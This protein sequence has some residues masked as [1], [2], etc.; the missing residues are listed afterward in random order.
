MPTAPLAVRELDDLLSQARESLEKANANLDPELVSVEQAHHLL[1][2]YA[3]VQRLAAYGETVLARRVDDAKAVAAATGTTVGKAKE[4]LNTGKAMQGASGLDQAMRS[5]ELSADQA[6]PIAKALQDNPSAEDSLLDAAR[7][8]SV[9]DLKERARKVSLDAQDRDD[10]AKRQRQARAA[11]ISRDDLGMV[12]ISAWFE[13]HVGEPIARRLDAQAKRR[14]RQ[15]KGAGEPFAASMADAL[16]DMLNGTGRQAPNVEMTILV[17]HEVAC[18][19]WT[20]VEDGEF[21]KIPGLGPISALTAKD[22]AQDAFLNGVF[23]DG[24]DLRQWQRFGRYKSPELRAALNL[25]PPPDFEG[26]KCVD[27]GN[28]LGLESDHVN[29]VANGGA[30]SY[31]NLRDRCWPCHRAKTEADRKAGLLN[32]DRDD[33]DDRAPPGG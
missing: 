15:A 9:H 6:A 32:S 20:H 22:L 5:G 33:P 10:L 27:C 4:T 17:S 1:G 21:C 25:G 8:G 31:E 14:Y 24:T 16:A 26:R 13:P 7:T 18:R 11:R 28:R 23:F 30:T 2:A 12:R 19:G 3:K 29:P